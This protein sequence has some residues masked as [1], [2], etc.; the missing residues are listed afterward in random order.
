MAVGKLHVAVDGELLSVAVRLRVR[1]PYDEKRHTNEASVSSHLSQLLRNTSYKTVN[2]AGYL[3]L[4]LEAVLFQD[5][6]SR[7]PFT[8]GPPD[9]VLAV[10]PESK[11][12]ALFKFR[13]FSLREI[14]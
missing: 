9:I 7:G 4:D 6:T 13:L 5:V 11:F 3:D 1:V 2:F 12:S 8:Q 14:P 10:G